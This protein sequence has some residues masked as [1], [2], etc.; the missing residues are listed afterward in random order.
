MDCYR[1]QCATN[2]QYQC[3]QDFEGE[4]C[5][6]CSQKCAQRFNGQGQQGGQQGQGQQFYQVCFIQLSLLRSSKLACKSQKKTPAGL[7]YSKII[8][9]LSTS[10]ILFCVGFPTAAVDVLPKVLSEQQAEPRFLPGPVLR[11]LQQRLLPKP[12]VPVPTELPGPTVPGVCS[13]VLPA[14]LRR[15]QCCEH[16][17][18]SYTNLHNA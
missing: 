14:V 16:L 8:H 10:I 1:Q 2:P 17:Y 3:Q 9:C 13:K 11:V 15:H 7:L 4:Q 5:Q 18:S 6:Q 12:S